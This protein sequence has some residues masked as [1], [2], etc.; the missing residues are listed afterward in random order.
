ME[1]IQLPVY[2]PSEKELTD[3]KLYANNVRAQM[4]AE[5]ISNFLSLCS[6]C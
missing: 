4:A 6:F 2:S 3:P 1:V 5:V